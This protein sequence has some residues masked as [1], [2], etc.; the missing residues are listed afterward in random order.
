MLS[1]AFYDRVKK[2]VDFSFLQ[3]RSYHIVSIQTWRCKIVV[4]FSDNLASQDSSS[5]D[6]QAE[7]LDADGK[8]LSRKR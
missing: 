2:D 5:D 4:E 6:K 3:G 1:Q 7:S 8:I